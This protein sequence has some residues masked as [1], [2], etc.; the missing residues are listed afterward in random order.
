VRLVAGRVV[1]Q[2]AVSTVT[3]DIDR[4]GLRGRLGAGEDDVVY[5][6]ALLWLFLCRPGRYVRM[7]GE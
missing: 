3:G 7:D 5:L 1:H 6:A 2:I 4:R